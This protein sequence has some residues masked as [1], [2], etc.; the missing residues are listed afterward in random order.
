MGRRLTAGIRNRKRHTHTHTH[1]DPYTIG[2]RLKMKAKKPLSTVIHPL[3]QIAPRL[4]HHC[5]NYCPHEVKGRFKPFSGKDGRYRNTFKWPNSEAKHVCTTGSPY[6]VV[7][8]QAL[9]HP[10][11]ATQKLEAGSNAR[12]GTNL[13][14]QT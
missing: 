3:A 1:P 14:P 9:H 11:D 4:G 13:A 2:H 12:A 5:T 7:D 10:P 8:G 6:L